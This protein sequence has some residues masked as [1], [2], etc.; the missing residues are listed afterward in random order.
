MRPY[1]DT[2][3]DGMVQVSFTLPLPHDKRAEGAAAAARRTRWAW[4]P[5]SSCTPRRW[6]R[7]SRSSSSTARSN[8]LVDLAPVEV[9]EREYPLL[10]R[11][12]G[13]RR[14]QDAAAAQ[15]RRG[16]RLHRHRRPHRRHRRD[17]QHQGLRG[18]EGPGVLPRAQG[19]EPRRAGARCPSW[20]SG[21]APRRPTPSSCPRSSPSATRTCTT[22]G[23]VGGLP[24]GL[25]GGPAAAARRRRPAV[26]RVGDGRARRRP[27]LRPRHDA[28]RGRLVPRPRARPAPRAAQRKRSPTRPRSG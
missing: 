5:R 2:T 23:D 6:G 15:A 11:Q 9:V 16:R 27:D 12:G 20:S 21:P 25:P 14:D 22:P 28:R 18:G 13:Q 24:R 8:H 26:R 7:T 10:T 17:P 1:G 4:T 3:G 19:R